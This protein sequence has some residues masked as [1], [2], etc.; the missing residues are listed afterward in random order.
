MRFHVTGESATLNPSRAGCFTSDV[1]RGEVALL[2]NDLSKLS[3]SPKTI[4]SLSKFSM[5]PK[6]IDNITTHAINQEVCRIF[7]KIWLYI[8]VKLQLVFNHNNEALK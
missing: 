2:L 7:R 6:T 3:V 1:T 5:S 4:D 8:D